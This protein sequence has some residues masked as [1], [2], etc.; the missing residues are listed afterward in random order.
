MEKVRSINELTKGDKIFR[1]NRYG[2]LEII[3]FLCIHPHNSGYS[4]FLDMNYD[5][6]KKFWND[7][8]IGDN[9][10]FYNPEERL[11]IIKMQEDYYNQELI[12]LAKLRDKYAKD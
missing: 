10:Y 4:V 9:W 8:L 3:E 12:E 2:E 11:E 1:L 7:D 5:P 6:M